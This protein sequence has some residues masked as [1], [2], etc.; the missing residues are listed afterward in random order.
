MNNYLKKEEIEQFV[1]FIEKSN[2]IVLTCHVRPDGDAIGSC[3]GLASILS[4]LGKETRVVVPDMP[5]KSLSFLP[6]FKEIAVFS[7]YDPYCTRIVKESDLIICCDFNKPS[8]QDHLE[9]LIQETEVNK[10]LIDH[11]LYPDDFANLTISYPEMSSTCELVFRLVAAAGFYTDMDKDSA[12]CL[13]T[14]LVTDTRNFTVNCKNP[15]IYEVLMRLL[16]KGA[17]KDRIVKLALM[18]SSYWSVKLHAY[19]ISNKMEVFDQHHCSIIT[20]D[21][22]ELQDFHYERG[23]SEGLVNVPLEIRGMVYSFFL[24]EDDDCIKISARSGFDFP[25]NLM[26]EE[27]YGGGG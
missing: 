14:G 4:V 3:L 16:E 6:G 1:A 19:A 21:K 7:K 27:L 26:C 23:D 13:L 10:I 9:P 5:P 18:T 12:T 17:N 24:R 8:R 20:L 25:V 11:H 22:Q 15:D 2:K